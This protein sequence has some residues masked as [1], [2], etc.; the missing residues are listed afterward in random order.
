L[1]SDRSEVVLA[2]D[3]TEFDKDGHATIALNM[4]TRH[5]R[6]TP[7]MWKTHEK[8]RLAKHR[9][10]FEDE[11][12]AHFRTIVL[13][14]ESRWPGASEIVALY[15]RRF[16]IEED[17]RDTKDPRFGL[18]LS[19]TRVGRTDHRDRLLLL[20][21]ALAQALL[22]LLGA[23]SEDTG[24]DRTLK[25]NTVKHRTMSLLNQGWFC[26]QAIPACAT[27]ACMLT[28]A[29]GR[30]GSLHVVCREIFGVILGDWSECL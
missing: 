10:D 7:L 8:S 12:L 20:M 9:N 3:W 29:F 2:L 21:A 25:A 1:L 6:A 4:L 26:Y 23:A 5:G 17:F 19:A 27:S 22:T 24:L 14:N 18:G 15:G 13:G 28:E 11:L 30:T 16:T